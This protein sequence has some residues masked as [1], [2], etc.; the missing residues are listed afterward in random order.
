MSFD[1]KFAQYGQLVLIVVL[2]AVVAMM[3]FPI[4]KGILD[5]LLVINIVGALSILLVAIS[6]SDPI[7][8]SSFSTLLLISTLF[9]LG[10]NLSS[11]RLIL[12]EGEAGAIIT[13][14]GH[15]V[16]RGNLLVGVVMFFVLMIVQFMVISKG[17]ERVAEVAAR[18]TLDALPGKQMSIDADLRAGLL[19]NEET[20]FKRAEL[21]KESK[22]Y[23]SLDGAMKFVKGD[24]LAGFVIALV[25]GVGGLLVG[26]FQRGLTLSEAAH[27]YTILSIGEALVAQISALLISLSAGFIVTRV[28]SVTEENNLG[29]ELGAQILAQ[30]RALL[31]TA[32]LAFGLGFIP[33]FPSAL[34]WLVSVILAGVSLTIE[35]KNR[36]LQR[37]KI[38]VASHRVS[39]GNPKIGLGQAEP[40]VLELGQDLYDHFLTDDRWRL[41]LNELFPELKQR[42]TQDLG[43][44]FPDLKIQVN[45]KF[46]PHHYRVKIYEI[47]VDEGFLSPE[48]CGIKNYSSESLNLIRQESEKTSETFHGTPVL[49]L[50]I[51]R[52]RELQNLGMKAMAPEDFLLMHLARVLK[53]N[54][55]E[56]IGIQEVK[57]T[58]SQL[59]LKYPELVRE[60][61]PRLISINKLTDVI[62]RLVEEGIPA[63]DLRLILEILSGAQPDTK[64]AVD[65]T[66]IV[67]IGMKRVISHRYT[68]GSQK[69]VC[70]TLDSALEETLSKALSRQGGERYLSLSPEQTKDIV[71]T[72]RRAYQSHGVSVRDTVILTQVECRRTL[73]KI[74]ELELPGASVLSYPEIAANVTIE[75]RDTIGLSTVEAETG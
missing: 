62:K 74:I 75:S 56:F 43:V 40:L 18:F 60:V 41:C 46:L 1:K 64:D 24:T 17:S 6:I 72:I 37:A 39:Y 16:V 5:F 53:E 4:P 45:D 34:F 15:F 19:T 57:N 59:E 67:R 32:G 23:G 8:L 12:S 50:Q 70:F 48:H 2:M 36:D 3:M 52:Q 51:Q 27:L 7:K 26:V 66:E 35:Y 63:K 73:R 58:L 11:T 55:A 38:S 28:T 10:L 44:V 29:N 61:V 68:R 54:A 9:R 33:G 47:P 13:T 20:K 25:N 31:V 14:F 69:L 42:L 71:A 49:L 22:L 30:P 65:L 21:I